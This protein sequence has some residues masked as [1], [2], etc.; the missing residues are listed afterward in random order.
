LA[1]K[2]GRGENRRGYRLDLPPE[3]YE[4]GAAHKRD[5]DMTLGQVPPV[6]T[7]DQV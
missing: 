6:P 1:S 4:R 2:V 7:V 3:P 5:I